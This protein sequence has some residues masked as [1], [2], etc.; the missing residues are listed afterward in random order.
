MCLLLHSETSGSNF[1]SFRQRPYF[2]L[3]GEF[4]F[5]Q[6][7]ERGSIFALSSEG[8]F[9]FP[10]KMWEKRPSDILFEVSLL[11]SRSLFHKYFFLFFVRVCVRVFFFHIPCMCL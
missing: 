5:S 11:F 6:K 9:V 1:S 2:F 7:L 4:A 10:W 8:T 3:I